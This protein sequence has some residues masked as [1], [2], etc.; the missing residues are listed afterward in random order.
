MTFT[1]SELELLVVALDT[2]EAE[3]LKRIHIYRDVDPYTRAAHK[4]GELHAR[5][6]DQLDKVRALRARIE[7]GT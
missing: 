7:A 1:P 5:D 2:R 6:E 3:L 4:V